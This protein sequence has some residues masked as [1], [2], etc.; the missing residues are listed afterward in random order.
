MR[1]DWQELLNAAVE[2]RPAQVL[3]WS[4]CCGS[5]AGTLRNIH[6]RSRAGGRGNMSNTVHLHIYA[7]WF[8]LA[9]CPPP[10]PPISRC[11]HLR[12]HYVLLR[13][14]VSAA[15][16]APIVSDVSAVSTV[17]TVAAVS[18][19]STASTA[20]TVSTAALGRTERIERQQRGGREATG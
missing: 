20:S 2:F 10:L 4:P 19:V 8:S 7:G 5:P 14:T 16:T 12:Y 18:T 13:I 11:V 1:W 15:P 9:P 6:G 17:S 3:A